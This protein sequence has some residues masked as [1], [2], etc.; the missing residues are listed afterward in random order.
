MT[1]DTPGGDRPEAVAPGRRRLAVA[2]LRSGEHPLPFGLPEPAFSLRPACL[3]QLGRELGRPFPR[4]IAARHRHVETTRQRGQNVSGTTPATSSR[5]A[6]AT[7]EAS[8]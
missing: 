7:R 3:Y 2:G 6:I 5:N 8:E 1:A 4:F